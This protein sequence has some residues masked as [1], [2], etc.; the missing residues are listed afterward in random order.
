M[1]LK[2]KMQNLL[3]ILFT[4]PTQ[5]PWRVNFVQSTHLP[6][7]ALNRWI[8]L[9]NCL[10]VVLLVGF[11][12]QC[13]FNEFEIRDF[14]QKQT[15]LEAEI[16]R[17]STN[18]LYQKISAIFEHNCESL[19]ALE[20]FYRNEFNI[21]L[22]LA[23]FADKCPSF[24]IVD[25]FNFSEK[26]SFAK[27]EIKGRIFGDNE[28]ALSSMEIFKDEIRQLVSLQSTQSELSILSLKQIEGATPAQFEYSLEIALNISSAH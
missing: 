28:T 3:H 1:W 9:G 17:A 20:L 16:A 8:F 27:I 4:K 10:A 19:K 24:S 22:F 6:N 13:A 15:E 25:T 21:L 18:E 11:F 2:T 26:G 12:I 7:R 14:N 23:D 5:Q